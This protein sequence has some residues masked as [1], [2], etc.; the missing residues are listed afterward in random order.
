MWSEG[1]LCARYSPEYFT[2]RDPILSTVQGAGSN[3]T[4][5]LGMK[6]QVQRSTL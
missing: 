6:T 4:P 2:H 5:I 1:L 3:G